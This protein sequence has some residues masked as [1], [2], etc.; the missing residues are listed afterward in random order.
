M[1]KLLLL[2]VTLIALVAEAQAAVNIN[3][4]TQAELETLQGIGPTKAK[5]II[6][7]RKKNGSFKSADDLQKVSGIGPAT[8]Q[9]LRK[10]I[11]ISG[12]SAVKK[13]SKPAARQ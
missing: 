10:D 7:H 13:E 6:D 9:K 1:K 3:T 4:A 11:T 12:A 8:V 2:F 5:A